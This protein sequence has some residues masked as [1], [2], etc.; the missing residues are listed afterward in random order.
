M[1]KNVLR[2]YYFWN[3]SMRF[4]SSLSNPFLKYKHANLTSKPPDTSR[5]LNM[6]GSQNVNLLMPAHFLLTQ[7]ESYDEVIKTR[8]AQAYGTGHTRECANAPL[9]A[10]LSYNM[11]NANVSHLSQRNYL[12]PLRSRVIQGDDHNLIGYFP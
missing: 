4:F 11:L 10:K 8:W 2:C 1:T 12:F 7:F 6:F 5:F 3:N 9:S